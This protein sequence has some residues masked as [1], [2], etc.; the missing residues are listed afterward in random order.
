MNT[1]NPML[2]F[3]PRKVAH[4]EVTNYVAYYQKDWPTLH[5]PIH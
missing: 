4:Y 5:E 2:T 1:P 3:D